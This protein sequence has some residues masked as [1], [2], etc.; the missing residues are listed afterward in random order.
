MDMSDIL[1]NWRSR[2]CVLAT[3]HEKET[4]IAPLMHDSLGI[5]VTVAQHF[6]TDRFGTFTR[7]TKRVGTQ[8]ETARAKAKAALAETGLD[9]AL[10][11]EGSFGSHPSIPF[12]ANNL[13]LV[14]LLDTKHN[15]EIVGHNTT[16]AVQAR[17]Q[18]VHSAEEA[19]TVAT[20]WGFPN[21]GVILRNKETSNRHIYKDL[22][23]KPDLCATVDRL[24]SKFFCTSLFLETDMRAHRCPARRES[25]KLATVDLIRNCRSLCPVCHAPGFVVSNVLPGAVCETCLLPT[26]Q[27]LDLISSCSTC[28]YVESKPATVTGT[29]SAEFC[30]TCNP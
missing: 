11:S 18:V 21:Q 19:H 23:T 24:L 9:L 27:V 14:I 12:L 2:T 30:N 8:L 20:S 10:A 3:M 26:D 15:L 28:H 17:G 25:I 7:D 16:S 13:E 6:N 29:V 4:L 22:I 5:T 1:S